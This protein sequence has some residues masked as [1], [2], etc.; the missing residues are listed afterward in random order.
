MPHVY[1]A[2][3]LPR[4]LPS[5]PSSGDRTHAAVR[6]RAISGRKVMPLTPIAHQ[7]RGQG[8]RPPDLAVHRKA[9]CC[10]GS[11]SAQDHIGQRGVSPMS[12]TPGLSVSVISPSG[13]CSS[14]HFHRPSKCI[15]FIGLS[16]RCTQIVSTSTVVNL[17]R[18]LWQCKP[19]SQRQHAS[20]QCATCGLHIVPRW[21]LWSGT[22]QWP[23]RPGRT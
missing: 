1:A 17:C 11:E 15:Y 4:R 5:D 23:R 13:T 6:L 20:L 10:V 3:R 2:L 8:V 14:G 21:C 9:P 12:Q 16:A 19:P 7:W 22:D 18:V